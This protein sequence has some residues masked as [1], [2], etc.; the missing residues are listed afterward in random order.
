MAL[1]LPPTNN[2]ESHGWRGE[3]L[4][5]DLDELSHADEVVGPADGGADDDQDDVH[6][7]VGALELDARVTEFDKVVRQRSRGGSYDNA[8]GGWSGTLSNPAPNAPGV[9]QQK[10]GIGKRCSGPGTSEWTA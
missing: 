6:K 4:L 9:L 5:L 8:R 10:C 1:D 3:P 2:A 7:F